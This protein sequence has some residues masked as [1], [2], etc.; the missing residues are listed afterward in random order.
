MSRDSVEFGLVAAMER[1]VSGLM[2][3]WSTTN[4][5]V[6][7]VPWKIHRG[8]RAALICA[9][10]GVAHSYAA[11]KVLVE[12]CS[13]RVMISIGFVGSCV[14]NLGPGSVVVP[15]TV[16]EAATGRKFNCAYGRGQVVTLDQIAGK[17]LKQEASARFDAQAVDMEATGV[18][19][20]AAEY[21]RE[22]A[23]IKVISDGAEED[24]S[25]LSGF[26][27]PEGFATGQFIA[28]I[29]L[30]PRLWPSVSALRRNS[31]LAST[32]LESAV[33]ECLRDWRAFSA[34]YSSEAAQ[35]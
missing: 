3:G 17:A 34:K 18:A 21:N 5:R 29:A 7:D 26:V 20:A 15:A 35:V 1:E 11:A 33:R 23:A 6:A 22:F 27:K 28:Y 19:A 24:L 25:F 9:G 10:I 30:R 16:V 4:V 32:S 12:E 2:R 31:K 13:P 14:T 8:Q